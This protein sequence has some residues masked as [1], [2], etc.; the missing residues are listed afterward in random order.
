MGNKLVPV[1]GKFYVVNTSAGRK[2]IRA[3]ET[4]GSVTRIQKLRVN[5]ARW[6][7]PAWVSIA[8]LHDCDVRPPAKDERDLL[9]A[10]ERADNRDEDL[11]ERALARKT[12]RS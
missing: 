7:L 8:W 12:V 3:H 4:K 6:T 11:G 5:T 2:L 10:A 1:Q 9:R